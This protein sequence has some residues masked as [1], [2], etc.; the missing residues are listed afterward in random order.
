MLKCADTDW[1]NEMSLQ[2]PDHVLSN[3]HKSGDNTSKMYYYL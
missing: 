3:F 1:S 2:D